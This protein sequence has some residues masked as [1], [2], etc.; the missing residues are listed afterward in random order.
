MIVDVLVVGPMIPPKTD[1]QTFSPAILA[2]D[3]VVTIFEGQ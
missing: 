3:F 1:P 2:P